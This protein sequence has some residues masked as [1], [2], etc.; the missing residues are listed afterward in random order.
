[1]IEILR[2]KKPKKHLEFPPDAYQPSIE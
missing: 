1:M 2:I